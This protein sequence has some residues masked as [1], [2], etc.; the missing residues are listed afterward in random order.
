MKII[1]RNLQVV[2][3]EPSKIANA[4]LKAYQTVYTI[5]D[6]ERHQIEEITKKVVYDLNDLRTEQIPISVVQNFVEHRLLDYGEI[7]VAEQYIDYRLQ[8][9]IER[10]GYGDRIAVRVHFDKVK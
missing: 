7:K 2:D 4:I 9:D 8:R 10:A 3:F 5:T 1:K 6:K